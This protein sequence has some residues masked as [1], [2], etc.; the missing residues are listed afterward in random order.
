[1]QSWKMSFH[2]TVSLRHV[3]QQFYLCVTLPRLRNSCALGVASNRC[4]Q[5]CAISSVKQNLG[6]SKGSPDLFWSSSLFHRLRSFS[7]A[8]MRKSKT[9]VS[10]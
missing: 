2:H 8:Q 7:K 4:A 6:S 5:L 10:D 9:S 1:M 3:T